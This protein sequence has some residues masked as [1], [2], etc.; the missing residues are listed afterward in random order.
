M[1]RKE[2]EAKLSALPNDPGCYQMKDKNG[3]IIYVG[4]AKNLKNRVRQYF[5]GTH[6]NKTTK[7]VSNIADFD[8]VVT[9]TEKEALVLEINL[10][11]QYTPRFNIQFMDSSTY[12]YIKLSGDE[13][14]TLRA[15]RD[16]KRDRSSR[17][18][19]PYPDVGSARET[20]N[21]LN[22]IFPFRKCNKMPNKVCL[23]YH[24]GECC[25]PCEGLVTKEEYAQLKK[26]FFEK[27]K[28][29]GG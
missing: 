6:D 11:K 22:Q 9:K 29:L 25:G 2:L 7:M 12:P 3:T 16:R 4:K 26:A 14:P 23:Y 24:L 21:L 18:F 8:Y 5:V 10:I 17:Y 19:G 15:V 13:F 27:E 1:N 28:N 20:I